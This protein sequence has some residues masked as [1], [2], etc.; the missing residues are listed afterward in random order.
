MNGESLRWTVPEGSD[1]LTVE[2][3]AEDG[4]S[5]FSRT[6]L[7]GDSL[8]AQLSPGR[9]RY[10][11]QAFVGARA[12]SAAEGPA[13]VEAVSDELLP[14][15]RVSLE[16]AAAAAALPDVDA[17]RSGGYRGLATLGWPYLI[18]IALFCG[19]WALRRWS[20]LR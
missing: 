10:R 7:A 17:Q 20:G 11:A 18:I 15:P 8:A 13:E 12:V 3:R 9:Y 16:P 19:E 5:V 14:R 6:A 4:Q 2:L 1:S